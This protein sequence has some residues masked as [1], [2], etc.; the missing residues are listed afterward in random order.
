M[1]T[2]KKYYWIKLRE[3]FMTGDVVDYLMS[4]PDGANYVVLYY[5]LCIKAINTD[6]KLERCV[7]EMLI[8]F[9]IEK[10]QRECKWFTI[11]TI[12]VALEVFQR[13]D[14]IY[15]EENGTIS[16]SH[17]E[18]LVGS[19]TDYA[20]QKR[21]QRKL[22][23]VDT[24]VDNVHTRDI[25]NKEYKSLKD[26]KSNKDNK[27]IKAKKVFVKPTL[28]E[29]EEYCRERNNGIDAQEFIDYYESQGWRKSNGQKVANWKSCIGTWES[30]RK[31]EK[32]KDNGRKI[33][34]FDYLEE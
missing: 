6:G 28:E 3:S 20:I 29:V 12:R 25:E 13:L 1:A 19:E 2:G 24:T 32:K 27:T 34:F 21:E 30:K 31:K 4:Q 5:M 9:D 26:N 18:E 16:I 7:G 10:I 23:D 15:Q 22:K 8:P 17:F 11:D 14:L 33:D